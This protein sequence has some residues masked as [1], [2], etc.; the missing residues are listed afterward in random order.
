MQILHMFNMLNLH[1]HSFNLTVSLKRN[2]I[3][4]HIS[5]GT[6]KDAFSSI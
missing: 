2:Y 5:I 6:N 3:K 4:S 1:K